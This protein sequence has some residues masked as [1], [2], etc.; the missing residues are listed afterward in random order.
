MWGIFPR[1][2]YEL[3]KEKQDGWEGPLS[4]DASVELGVQVGQ[5]QRRMTQEEMVATDFYYDTPANCL[6]CL[7]HQARLLSVQAHE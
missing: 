6:V 4:S 3:C 5:S 7:H 1:L 2:G